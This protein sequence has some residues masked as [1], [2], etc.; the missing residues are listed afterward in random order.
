[1]RTL[2]IVGGIAPSSTIEYYREYISAWR[3][4]VTD[5]CYPQIV[6]NSMNLTPMLELLHAN[7]W[8]EVTD[9]FVRE[10]SVLT[11]AGVDVALLASNTPH[12]V[13]DDIQLRSSVRLVSIVT[14]TRD[15]ALTRGITKLG[16]VGSRFTMQG[17]VYGRAFAERGMT[18]VT[19][20]PEVQ[21]VIHAHYMNEF[22]HG[23]FLEATRERLI[24]MVRA[25]H[26][27]EGFSALI[28]GGTELPFVFTDAAQVGVPLLDT[29]RIHVAAALEAMLAP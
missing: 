11:R 26:R 21:E 1:M 23:V 5:G 18:V 12:L 27:K 4:R 2:G 19:P 16:L 28:L 10:L 3:T 24:E 17:G 20:E 22:V 15:E 9:L 13:F 6:I 14:A 8:A 7:R 29:T 25:W